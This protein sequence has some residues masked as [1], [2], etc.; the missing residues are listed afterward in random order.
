MTKLHTLCLTAALAVAA[1]LAQAGDLSYDF[2]QGSFI[3]TSIDDSDVDVDS[4]GAAFSASI[5]ENAFI[6]GSYAMGETDDVT[7]TG[8]GFSET[9]S[10]EI[11]EMSFGIGGRSAVGPSTDLVGDIRYLYSEIEA[12]DFSVSAEEDGDGFGVSLGA[13]HGFSDTFEGSIGLFH[14][15]IESEDDTFLQIGGLLH[16]NSKVSLGLGYSTGSE[17]TSTALSLRVNL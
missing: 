9:G 4:F 7:I 14:A 15:E 11:T 3:A 12:Q 2:I 16:L 5:S 17:A 1:P 6:V 13:R 8:P 10:F